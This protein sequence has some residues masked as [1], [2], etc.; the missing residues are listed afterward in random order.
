MS[1]ETLTTKLNTLKNS[2]SSIKAAIKVKKGGNV[3]G[4]ITTFADEILN[5]TTDS[6]EETEDISIIDINDDGFEK[7]IAEELADIGWSEDDI[8]FYRKHGVTWSLSE[9]AAHHVNDDAKNFYRDYIQ[10][11]GTFTYNTISSLM[12]N[13]NWCPQF[14]EKMKTITSLQL[15]FAGCSFYGIPKLDMSTITNLT[16]MFFR[17]TNLTCV[18]KM[19]YNET[20]ITS[21]YGQFDGCS[22]LVY[23]DYILFPAG[24]NQYMCRNCTHLK[25]VKEIKILNKATNLTSIFQNCMCLEKVN[26]SSDS[27]LSTTT[28]YTNAFSGCK[29]L[30]E[31]QIYIGAKTTQFSST[32][33]DCDELQTIKFIGTNA[34]GSTTVNTCNKMFANCFN[35]KK[36]PDFPFPKC[37]SYQTMFSVDKNAIY[38]NKI[39]EIGEIDM[40]NISSSSGALLFNTSGTEV[41]SVALPNLTTMGG[42]KNLKVSLDFSK[43]TALTVESVVNIISK[44][45]DTVTG[46]TLTFGV[47]LDDAQIQAAIAAKPNWTITTTA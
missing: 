8:E 25:E 9:N 18:P 29:S 31:L 7:T 42:F 5:L 3:L 40:S 26:Y 24:T 44:V 20:A 36:I 13:A 6:G 17:C 2:V 14:G 21:G 27:N 43:F 47:S 16:N 32:F 19:Y 4:D 37:S 34:T 45:D 22:S 15:S 46:Q 12:K 35:L 23:A 1:L 39:I 41:S 33:A 10:G 38:L 11:D 30:K 28:D